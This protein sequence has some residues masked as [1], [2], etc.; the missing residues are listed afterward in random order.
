MRT[1]RGLAVCITALALVSLLRAQPGDLGAA[2][3]DTKELDQRIYKVLKDVI[4]T[5]ARIY[6]APNN[7]H[8]GCYRLYEGSLITLKP[9]L[10]HRPGLQKVID[11]AFAIAAREQSIAERAFILRAALDRIRDETGGKP[12]AGKKDVAKKGSL[13]DRLG[14]EKNVRKVVDD[15]VG[16][17]STDPK[18]DFFRA[19]N[20][21]P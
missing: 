4:N 17:A 15:F 5:G 3:P 13:W 1:T 6:N 11:D 14:G 10:D 12:A 9:L 21:K 18:V 7:D 8:S 20:S 16:L 2:G 19:G